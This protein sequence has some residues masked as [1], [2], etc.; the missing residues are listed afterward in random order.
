MLPSWIYLTCFWRQK[1]INQSAK[2][3]YKFMPSN[4]MYTVNAIRSK[5]YICKLVTTYHIY[6]SSDILFHFRRAL[7]ATFVLIPLFG[8]QWAFVIHRPSFTLWYEVTRV[9]I[10][11]T[12][13]CIDY[14]YSNDKIPNFLKGLNNIRL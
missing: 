11:Y 7:K 13:V 3:N 1:R 12:Q 10:Q 9:I 5:K 2:R 4:S 14:I 6:I 8:M